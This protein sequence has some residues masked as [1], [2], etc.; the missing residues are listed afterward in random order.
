MTE[1]VAVVAVMSVQPTSEK[2]TVEQLSGSAANAVVA[3]ERAATAVTV[4][5]LNALVV[6]ILDSQSYV[7]KP[8][9]NSR[10]L[11]ATSVRL[12]RIGHPECDVP[13]F[14]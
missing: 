13:H 5:S 8:S 11:Q 3:T 6:F 12:R 4:I 2:R 7:P 14:S 1:A 10:H 9:T